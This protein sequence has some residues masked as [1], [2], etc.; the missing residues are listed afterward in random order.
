MLKLIINLTQT[1]IDQISKASQIPKSGDY[2]KKWE[3][4]RSTLCSFDGPFQLVHTD[5]AKLEF[6]G[7]SAILPRYA[8]LA[9]DPY[10]SNI[11]CWSLLVK[12]LCL[13]YTIK[14]QILQKLNRFYDEIKKKKKKNYVAARGQWIPTRKTKIFKWQIWC[15]GLRKVIPQEIGAEIE[16]GSSD[17]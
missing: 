6:L 12:K 11:Y 2:V 3:I 15:R 1:D 7:T 16:S 8:L 17:N 10:S 14:K 4:D 5:V 9:V 13:S